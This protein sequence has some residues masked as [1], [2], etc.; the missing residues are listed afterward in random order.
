MY[1][2]QQQQQMQHFYPS[3][4][5]FLWASEPSIH[6]PGTDPVPNCSSYISNSTLSVA[7]SYSYAAP[8]STDPQNWI[9]KQPESVGYDAAVGSSSSMSSSLPLTYDGTWLQQI[10]THEEANQTKGSKSMRCEVC[11]I[12]CN[13]KDVYEKHIFGKKHKKNMQIIANPMQ[14]NVQSQ[15]SVCSEV[16]KR[17]LSNGGAPVDSTK[18]CT[19]CNIVCN[20]Q[21]VYNK[22]IAGKKHAAQVALMSNNGIGPYIAAFKSQG[23]GPWKKAPKKVKVMQPVWCDTCK[24]T[25]NSRDMYVSHLAGKKHLKNLEKQS[26]PEASANAAKL[27]IG[28]Q[29]KPNTDKVKSEEKPDTD[30]PKAKKA[31]D[32]DIEAKKLKVVEGG[33]AADSVRTCTACNVVCNSET[34]F[35]AHLIGHK[36]AAMVKKQNLESNGTTAS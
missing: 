2:H 22:H 24:V 3:S 31:K 36:H 23:I 5:P 34:V 11:K 7:P 20:S 6:P 26:K 9:V 13:S 17:K 30:K 14:A 32:L 18:I 4:N 27:L 16:K 35:N 28:P 12:D 8:Q 15:T 33:T 21:D 29:E 1:P 25:C 19:I 10:F